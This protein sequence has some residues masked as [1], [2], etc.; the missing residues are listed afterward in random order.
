[1]FFVLLLLG[2]IIYVTDRTYPGDYLY[3]FKL[4]FEVFVLATSKIVNKQV[5]FS[6]DLVSRRSNEVAKILMS[7]Q[8]RESL[9]RLD[10]QVE[11]TAVSIYQIKDPIEKKMAAKKYV[12]KLSEVSL[13]L[14][15]EQ[16]KIVMQPQ[17]NVT[18]VPIAPTLPTSQVSQNA[19]PPV[20]ISQEIDNTQQTIEQTIDKM[21]IISHQPTAPDQAPTPTSTPYP[22]IQES[23]PIPTRINQSGSFQNTAAQDD[24]PTPTDI[25]QP[26][27]QDNAPTPT[28]IPQP[29]IQDN[30][31][32]P[33]NIPVNN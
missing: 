28:N 16:K 6:I 20:S 19:T 31:P 24:S 26:T 30:S 8:G 7:E 3:P 21:I 29:T 12:V 1:M 17:V 32:T 9:N 23:T 5:D 14:S 2:G 15:N 10:T 4:K 33:T 11:L 25:P 18:Q 27:I 13:A 22:T